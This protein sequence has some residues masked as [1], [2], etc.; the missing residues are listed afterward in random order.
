MPNTNHVL[1]NSGI[2]VELHTS[3]KSAKQSQIRWEKMG[4]KTSLYWVSENSEDTLCG[5]EV[6]A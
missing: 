1:T 6:G 3:P 5:L 2:R 4:F